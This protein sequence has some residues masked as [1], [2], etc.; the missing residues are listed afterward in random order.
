[1]ATNR[2]GKQM[3]SRNEATC[4]NQSNFSFLAQE[5]FLAQSHSSYAHQLPL[6]FAFYRYVR[7]TKLHR[8]TRLPRCAGRYRLP[9]LC[10]CDTIKRKHCLFV[11][12]TFTL[13]FFYTVLSRF[14]ASLRFA[15]L[16]FVATRSLP[17]HSPTCSPSPSPSPSLSPA[18]SSHNLSHT[19]LR[20]T[21]VIANMCVE[22]CNSCDKAIYVTCKKESNVKEHR[23]R[24]KSLLPV[25]KC[26]C[27]QPSTTPSSTS[28]SKPSKRSS[29]PSKSTSS[30]HSVRA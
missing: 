14:F 26:S 29:S 20:N 22:I 1:M 12:S 23:A 25:Y 9:R 18:S 17:H 24:W 8:R 15:L 11:S 16:S 3:R 13:F 10:V 5:L 19:T 21:T 28:S 4:Q 6:P 2:S 30:K 7:L 27:K